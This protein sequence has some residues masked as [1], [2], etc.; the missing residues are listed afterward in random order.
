MPN[1]RS[2]LHAGRS[3]GRERVAK[4][5]PEVGGGML[6]LCGD[7]LLRARIVEVREVDDVLF[8]L[9]GRSLLE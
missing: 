3:L 2:R 5:D 7:H 9:A 1:R 6:R 8:L 4:A